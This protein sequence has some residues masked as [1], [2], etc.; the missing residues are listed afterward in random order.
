MQAGDRPEANL[1]DLL[2][3]LDGDASDVPVPQVMA[4]SDPL[5]PHTAMHSGARRVCS[6]QLPWGR[7]HGDRVV[8]M[9]G[10]A[11]WT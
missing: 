6:C 2:S 10:S 5:R 1:I 9:V 7:V 4:R 8:A 3:G 11:G